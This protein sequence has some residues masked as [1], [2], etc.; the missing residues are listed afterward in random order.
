MRTSAFIGL[1]TSLLLSL[2]SAKASEDTALD[3][4]I[5]KPDNN[6]QY[7]HYHTDSQ[8]AYK[9]YFITMTSQQWRSPGEVDRVRWEHNLTITVPAVLHSNS[10]R[11][12]LL[13]ING[14]SNGGPL[15]METDPVLA[16]AAL[17][18]GSVI[19]NLRQVPNQPL[20][21]ADEDNYP[22]GEDALLAYSLDK[23]IDTGDEEWPVH[24]PMT[25]AAVRAMDTVQNFL[26]AQA[27]PIDDFIVFGGSKRGWTTWLTAAVDARVKAI[28]PISIDLLNMRR[29]FTHHWEAYGDYADAIDDYVAF[30]LPCRM[31]SARGRELL[32]IIDPYAYRN[33][34]TMPKFIVNSAG[35][36]FF[37]PDSSP[38]YFG[39]LPEPK[40]LR[41]TFNTDHSQL[42]EVQSMIWDILL[43]IDDINGGEPDPLYSWTLAEDGSIVVQT[44]NPPPKK[45]Y[46]WQ[47]TNSD[48]RDFR[49]QTIGPGWTKTEL[50]PAGLG[51]Y[52]GFV[53]PPPQGFTA[54][55]VELVFEENTPLGLLKADKRYTTDIRIT[56]DILPFAGTACLVQSPGYLENPQ[57][58][59]FQ[60][61]IAT[62]S[63]WS[64]NAERVDIEIDDETIIPAAYGTARADTQ[65]ACQDANNGFGLLLNMNLLGDGVHSV[66]ALA[67]G[68]QIGEPAAVRVATLGTE[69]LSGASGIYNLMGFPS[70]LRS[71]TL[72]WQE[73]LQ[74]FAI[75]A[76]GRGG[77]ASRSYPMNGPTPGQLENPQPSSYQSGITTVSGWVCDAA[78][79]DIQIDGVQLIQAAYGT[80]RADTKELCGDTDNG[81]GLLLNMNLLGDGIHTLRALADGREIGAATF[82]V[83]TFGTEFLVGASGAYSLP[84]FP[85][86]G[87]SVIV[88]WQESQQ[89]F[90]ITQ[91][92]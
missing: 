41:Y 24:L 1:L 70:P 89:N 47:A 68:R 60:S 56:P 63:G 35:D 91:R 11:T 55:A 84:D 14:G 42:D 21:F 32:D 59:A 39:A 69:F 38:F 27:V 46:L 25:K 17:A 64:C 40:R 54:F 34:Y 7:V 72:T 78:R 23:Y 2:V 79:V 83:T 71:V 90:T 80:S 19:V 50:Q 49:L 61:G 18:T 73:S 52:I 74:N 6:Y 12:A 43:W 31:Q 20:Y 51:K 26:T 77:I 8:L 37:L 33:R 44:A 62:V 13:L 86:A 16:V 10:R 48:A 45:V 28:A 85:E 87:E 81:F 9:T 88:E 75:A 58:G 36:Q 3:R 65:Q 22:R 92:Q 57:P 66:R 5:A 76:V 82:R 29:Q 67:D 4:Y 53:P 15:P 30:D